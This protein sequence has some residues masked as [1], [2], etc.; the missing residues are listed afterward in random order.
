MCIYKRTQIVSEQKLYVKIAFASCA[1]FLKNE[2]FIITIEKK[3]IEINNTT[4]ISH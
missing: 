2:D 1:W 4:K 3:N